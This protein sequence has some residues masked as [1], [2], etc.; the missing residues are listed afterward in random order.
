VCLCYRLN[1]ELTRLIHNK[2]SPEVNLVRAHQLFAH[3]KY[4]P[5]EQES[6]IAAF[7]QQSPAGRR[8]VQR[9]QAERTRVSALSHR[10]VS[11]V[12]TSARG[13][14]DLSNEELLHVRHLARRVLPAFD[15][16][17]S[18]YETYQLPAGVRRAL[19]LSSADFVNW[20]TQSELSSQEIAVAGG[21]P[22]RAAL[23]HAAQVNGV[24][25]TGYEREAKRAVVKSRNSGFM[26]D[27]RVNERKS[28]V[29]GVFIL[30]L[31]ITY[32][33]HSCSFFA[34]ETPL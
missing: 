23:F 24:S 4:L 34:N 32:A 16:L 27:P 22:A 1:G 6:S 20:A 5:P 31:I 29:F 26:L 13:L 14:V 12:S 18:T 11:F 2:T 33:C 21:P 8:L 30:R 7:M 19:P 25:Y 15:Q 10:G 28:S 3:R 17:C 9:R